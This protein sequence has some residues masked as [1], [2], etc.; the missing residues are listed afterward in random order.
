[1][2]KYKDATGLFED[3]NFKLVVIDSLLN[4]SP[5]FES[6]LEIL[7]EKYDK[8]EWYSTSGP[9][10]EM[11][12]FFS[13]LKLEPQDLDKVIELCFDGG[14]EIYH[15]IQPGWDG[16]DGQFDVQS[17][18]GFEHLKNL[19]CVCYIS[20]CDEEILNPLSNKGIEIT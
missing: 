4:R 16:E 9:I 8:F 18:S 20:T 2:D 5:S 3:F 13:N 17:V 7:K 1:M 19:K 10:E 15:L 11:L 6:E 14:N 12:G